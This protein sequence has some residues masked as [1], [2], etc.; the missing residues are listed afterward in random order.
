MLY[1][2]PRH[3]LA[4]TYEII[5]LWKHQMGWAGEEAKHFLG[6]MMCF[7]ISLCM[8]VPRVS[9]VCFAFQSAHKSLLQAQLASEN[10]NDPKLFENYLEIIQHSMDVLEQAF[11]KRKITINGEESIAGRSYPVGHSIME[12]KA[13]PASGSLHK[14]NY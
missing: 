2:F 13:S 10:K 1:H 3:D 6:F 4:E 9:L 14:G 11:R 7:K 8:P 12:E 5:G